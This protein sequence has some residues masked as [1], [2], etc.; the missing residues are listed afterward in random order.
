MHSVTQGS[1]FSPLL[2]HPL[3]A[4]P[5]LAT[6][7][8]M[9]VFPPVAVFLFGQ[10][11]DLRRQG[12]LTLP[13]LFMPRISGYG[14]MGAAGLRFPVTGMAD[15]RVGDPTRVGGQAGSTSSTATLLTYAI[16]GCK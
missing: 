7:F 6:G 12:D 10:F 14:G 13:D 11:E 5:P 9:G 16:R 4:L 15:R 2:Y 8:A 1:D 3:L